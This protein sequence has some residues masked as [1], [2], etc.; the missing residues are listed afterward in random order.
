MCIRCEGVFGFIEE[1]CKELPRGSRKAV[2][3]A[4]L[5][6]LFRPDHIC[7]EAKGYAYDLVSRIHNVQ[8]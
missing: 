5:N 3:K 7:P 8:E 2:H 4:V 6:I 1:M